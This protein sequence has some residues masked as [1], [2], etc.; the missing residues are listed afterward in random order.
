MVI[1]SGLETFLG[2]SMEGTQVQ[3]GRG[4]VAAGVS[5]DPPLPKLVYEYTIIIKT[6]ML[7]LARDLTR[8]WPA[9]WLIKTI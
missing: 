6:D 1:L 5:G 7:A 8:L 4:E 3:A 2:R 9:A